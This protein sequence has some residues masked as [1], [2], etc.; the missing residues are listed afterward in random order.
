MVE[1]Q[2]VRWRNFLATGNVFTEVELNKE[3]IT[4]ICGNNGS[5]KTTVIDALC[6]GLFGSTFR[7]IK[8]AQAVNTVNG[9][10]CEVEVELNIKGV[11]Y[12]IVRG[13]A[14]GKFE[15]YQNGKPLNEESDNRD[16]QKWFEKEIL[17][18]NKQVFIQVIV[19]GSTNYV[20]FM[21]LAKQ[22]R[23]DIIADILELHV[24]S[25]M[26]EILVVDIAELN[27]AIM[28]T[29]TDIRIND[30]DI[31]NAQK[32]L[33]TLN[34]KTREQIEQE[35]EDISTLKSEGLKGAGK[36]KELKAAKKS[37]SADVPNLNAFTEVLQKASTDRG[38][39]EHKRKEYA[40]QIKFFTDN[41]VCP[42]CNQDIQEAY[43]EDTLKELTDKLEQ[44][45]FEQSGLNTTIKESQD[46]I[47]AIRKQKQEISSI[48]ASI[49]R[50]MAELTSKKNSIKRK[51]ETIKRLA[52]EVK[53]D[54]VDTTGT[55]K[56]LETYINRQK[57]LSDVNKEQL[58]LSFLYDIAKQLL[59]DK[60]I[61]A[62][63]IDRYIPTINEYINDYLT[64]MDFYV[65]FQIDKEFSETIK[66]QYRSN[67]SYSSF[68]EG[69]KMRIDV[70]LLLTWRAIAKLKNSIKTNL[71]IIDEIFDSSLDNMGIEYVSHLLEKLEDTN[72]FLISHKTDVVMDKFSSIIKFEKQRNF[73]VITD[74]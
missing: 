25:K 69:E 68:S 44:A 14:P 9:K 16:R 29:N 32:T 7:Q 50:F 5:G 62:T 1:F 28:Q 31:K 53:N 33:K 13:Y 23:R 55:K 11:N 19:L 59:S 40:K 21:R 57:E 24:F 22:A 43:A 46:K 65:Q 37:K 26:S 58:S 2:K 8:K 30:N 36:L 61:K 66:S 52:E 60:G 63:I 67:F 35:R 42:T 45:V 20:P 74:E 17:G 72:V 49:A 70:A 10:N 41:A 39:L 6:F 27:H 34:D 3:P 4:L 56:N 12:R 18:F 71:L 15:I 47:D 48:E 38:I 51:Q 64:K 73:S 54:A